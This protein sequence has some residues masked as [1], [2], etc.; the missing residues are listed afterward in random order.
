MTKTLTEQWKDGELTGGLYYI[1]LKDGRIFTDRTRY[2]VGEKMYRWEMV[3]YHYVAEVLEAVPSF[4][5][6]K[7][8]LRLPAKYIMLEADNKALHTTN[9]KIC[10]ENK[11]LTRQLEIAIQGLKEIDS[12]GGVASM[13]YRVLLE[14]NSIDENGIRIGR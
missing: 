5:G 10:K 4:N 9:N 3:D 14:I 1:K 8:L 11:R 6:Y 13:A 7:E 12:P 2:E